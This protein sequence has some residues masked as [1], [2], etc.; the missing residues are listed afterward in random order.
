VVT[1]LEA[2][3]RLE[4]AE[5]VKTN[6][7]T[8]EGDLTKQI[9]HLISFRTEGA[10]YKAA[11][12]WGLRIVSIEWLRDSLERGMILDEKL[13]DPALPLDQRGIGAWNRTQPKK[14]TS[15]GKRPRDE[16]ITG[17]DGPKRKLRRTAS[18]KLNSQSE[19]LWGDIV[20]TGGGSVA[21]VVR[22]GAW[23]STENEPPEESTTTLKAPTDSSSIK[24][25]VAPEPLLIQ[26]MFSG[27][28]F[29]LE[30]FEFK[31]SQILSDHLIP[32][33]GEVS[34]SI[35]GLQAATPIGVSMRLFRIRPSTLLE[36]DSLVLPDSA[37]KVETITEWWVERCLYHKDFLEP[38]AHVIGRPFP[39]FP[40]EG[41]QELTINSAAF[42]GIDL[43]HFTKA[44]KLV[45]AKYNEDMTPESSLL[46]T[47]SVVGLRK[48]KAEHAQEWKIPIV[49]ATWLWDSIA[50]GEKLPTGKYKFRS[51]N[52]AGSVPSGKPPAKIHE[53][54]QRSKSNL[55]NSALKPD[56]G[57][58]HPSKISRNSRLD[59]TA[60][61]SED[62]MFS[63]KQGTD[64]Q[65]S[66][67]TSIVAE[68]STSMSGKS[69]P[70]SERSQNVPLTVSTAP[71]PPDHPAPRPTEDLSNDIS[72][73]LTKTKTAV[74]PAQTDATEGRKRGVNRILGRAT[75][76][77]S[78]GSISLSRASSVDSTATHG[79]PVEYP[80]NSNIS[81]KVA[82]VHNALET[83]H[84]EQLM[85]PEDDRNT[86]KNI[87]SQ[88]PMTQLEYEDPQSTEYKERVMARM[89]GEKVDPKRKGLTK[90][91]GITLGD[92]SEG[93]KPRA[94]RNAGRAAGFR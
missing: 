72:N 81:G 51:L 80:S 30:G 58:S 12:A 84:I 88:P 48:D 93:M 49:N 92:I 70:L 56:A 29:Y 64:T 9:T 26:G 6:G 66:I 53:Q 60:F 67:F 13:Y 34:G 54:A 74:Q 45:G 57:P 16:T 2:T 87:E 59:T 17:G 24:T 23:E 10:K 79:N 3:E 15:L 32:N 55:A 62:G 8:Y 68:P 52:R 35:E 78:T 22:S 11:K 19:D 90:E 69:E 46:L 85:G 77:V 75:S 47:K 86:N 37:S 76:N 38:S 27:C 39:K 50:A 41:F 31:K 14:R 83:N 42:S 28:R 89:L 18:T 1:I 7:A 4:I 25:E 73:L 5:T 91:K 65:I 61:E 40:I 71:A 36:E 21:Q 94:R 20:A 82:S 33:G 63:V 44:V 43:L